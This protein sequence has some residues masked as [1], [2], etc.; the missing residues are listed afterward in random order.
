MA[1]LA[2]PRPSPGCAGK[3]LV[4]YDR[5]FTEEGRVVRRVVTLAVVALVAPAAV[6]WGR[7]FEDPASHET[8]QDFARATQRADTP[9]DPGYDNAE[10]DDPDTTSP[11]TNVFDERFDLFGFPS[12]HTPSAVYKEGPNAGKPMIS[13]FNAAGAW[14]LTRGNPDVAVAI[15]DTG[16]KWERDALRTK[17]ALNRGELPQPRHDLTAPIADGASCA[18][19]ADAYD[20]NGDGAFNVDDYACDSRVSISAGPHSDPL[21]PRL[22]PEDLIAAFSDGHDDDGNDYVDDIA[23]W[24]FF[25]DDNNPYDSSRYF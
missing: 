14:K 17:I 4:I 15:L 25:D 20:A 2:G 10:P 9:N 11:S 5:R 7:D 23:G 3:W 21:H 18:S 13:G 8:A 6:A 19:Y 22:D 12:A 1:P 24:D 16:I